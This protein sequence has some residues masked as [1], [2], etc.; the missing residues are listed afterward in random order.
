MERPDVAV[1][2]IVGIFLDRLAAFA[3]ISVEA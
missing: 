1:G 2:H 3:C